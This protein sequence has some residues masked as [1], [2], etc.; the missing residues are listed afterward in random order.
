MS[1]RRST[2]LLVTQTGKWTYGTSDLLPVRTSSNY[3]LR[4][5]L[6]D[7]LSG[8][9]RFGSDSREGSG[10]TRSP[11]AFET[12]EVHVR[13]PPARAPPSFGRKAGGDARS[14]R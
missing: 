4:S 3:L 7:W 9:G 14:E 13:P 2:R 11:R 8:F 12:S 1:D 6:S 10:P 5:K